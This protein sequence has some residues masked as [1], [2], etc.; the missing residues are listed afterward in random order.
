MYNNLLSNN[1][2]KL[3]KFVYYFLAYPCLLSVLS[4]TDLQKLHGG[5][6]LC[7]GEWGIVVPIFMKIKIV[8]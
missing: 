7:C 3:L 2:L 6:L 4:L 5:I 1:L 8:I